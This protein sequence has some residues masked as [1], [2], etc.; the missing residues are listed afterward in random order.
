MNA[1]WFKRSVI[2]ALAFGFFIGACITADWLWPLSN[3]PSMSTN[4]T[5]SGAALVVDEKG[6]PL[7]AFADPNAI[8]RYPI[9]VDQ[10]SD[11]YLQALLGYEDRFYYYHFGINPSS[12]VRAAWQW[13]SHG[14]V[15]SGGSTLTMQVARIFYPHSRR[16]S[17]KFYQMFRALQL[18]WHFSK[19]QIL[20]LYINFA[21][22]GGTIQGVQAASLQY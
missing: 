9:S 15:V 16:I 18:E 8:W 12:L 7:R 10:V 6:T 17:G 4:K 21:P 11:D 22:Y 1:K 3:V 19:Q 14:K 2:V 20:S 13:L 5:H